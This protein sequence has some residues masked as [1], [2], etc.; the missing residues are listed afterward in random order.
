MAFY[1]LTAGFFLLMVHIRVRRGTETC[2][3]VLSLSSRT[4]AHHLS[5][6]IIVT[7]QQFPNRVGQ[8]NADNPEFQGVIYDP[9][10][11]FGKRFSQADIPT[12]KIAR[13]YH[14]TA[15]LTP[16]G[17]IMVAGS[18]PNLDVTTVKYATEYR[19]EWLSPSYLNHPRPTYTG[20]PTTVDYGT[21][22]KLQVNLPPGTTSVT[23][24]PFHVK[25]RHICGHLI[26][27]AC[28]PQSFF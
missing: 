24:K 17:R 10:L 9:T 26:K 2:V 7:T 27:T 5:F 11:P 16:D 23:G 20:L 12:S 21:T 22:F 14:S 3:L 4:C 8:S 1:F 13:M 19:V 18:N 15:T 6:I 28:L 25:Y